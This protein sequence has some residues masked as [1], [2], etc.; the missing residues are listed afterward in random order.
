[1]RMASA[2]AAGLVFGAGIAIS[3]MADPGK[4]LNFFDIAGTFD[5]SLVFVMFSAMLTAMAGY[6]FVLARDKP[7]YDDVF[8]LPTSTG[9]DKPLVLGSA[10][11]GIG[12]GIAGFCP[13]GAIPALALGSAEPLIFV[14]SMAAGM[15]GARYLRDVQARQR[16][17]A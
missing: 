2:L 14:V 8:H 15:L 5:P 6:R 11:F 16:L 4:V 3:G 12:W 9:V 1:M 13:G 10:A 17:A 7:L